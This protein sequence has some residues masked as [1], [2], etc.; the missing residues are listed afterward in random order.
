LFLKKCNWFTIPV[1]PFLRD[2]KKR[3]EN[4]VPIFI[5]SCHLPYK[6]VICDNEPHISQK[7]HYFQFV[8]LV[9]HGIILLA[10]KCENGFRS[11]A[12]DTP[13]SLPPFLYLIESFM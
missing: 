1:F 4:F 3:D 11:A 5:K 2:A 10:R 13:H 12:A 8:F 9:P 7:K 6:Y